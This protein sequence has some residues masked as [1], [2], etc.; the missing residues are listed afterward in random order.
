MQKRLRKHLPFL[1]F[2]LNTQLKQRKSVLQSSTPDQIKILSE[3]VQNLLEGNIPLTPKQK[4]ILKPHEKKFVK[5]I[6]KK[7]S[8][9]RLRG[10]WSKIAKTS[11]I[12]LLHTILPFLTK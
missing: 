5:V 11:L 12:I 9:N 4:R 1:Q 10:N 7:Q 2:L 3:I 6:G 8:I